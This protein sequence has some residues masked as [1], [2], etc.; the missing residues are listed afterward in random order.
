MYNFIGKAIADRLKYN[1]PLES[2]TKQVLTDKEYNHIMTCK[3][4]ARHCE[5]CIII[6]EKIDNNWQPNR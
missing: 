2:Q 3:T 4:Q 6:L 1:Q 5:Q